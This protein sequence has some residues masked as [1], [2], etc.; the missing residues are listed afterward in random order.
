M[1]TAMAKARDGKPTRDTKIVL[2]LTEREWLEVT[3]AART[4]GLH[5]FPSQWA[6]AKVLE[7]ARRPG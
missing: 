6:R 3:R 7:A 4:E 1:L 2:R 5:A